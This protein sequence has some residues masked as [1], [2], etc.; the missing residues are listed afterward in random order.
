MTRS[1]R[2]AHR[3][4]AI[5]SLATSLAA[6]VPALA[7]SPTVVA[8]PKTNITTDVTDIWWPD[9]EPGWGIQLIQNADIIFATMFVYG[10]DS[11]PLFFVA[12][13]QKVAGADTWTGDLYQS[14]GTFFADT[15]NPADRA[16]FLAGAM[17][18]TLTGIGSGTLSYN[19]G[20]TSVV[21]QIS[22]QALK[23]EDNSG[24]YRMTHTW[25]AAGAGCT[26]SD[27]YSPAAGPV[28]GDL[29]ISRV[30]ADTATVS[31]T[32]QLFP[33]DTCFMTATYT[34]VGRLG[35]Y[36]GALA[37]SP[38]GRTGT[39]ALYEIANRPKMLTGRYEMAWN[40]GCTRSGQF[41][42]IMA[43]P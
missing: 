39:L 33:V 1:L 3:A 24:D 19:V 26:S 41:T 32:W 36:S 31:L 16:E 23:L 27:L 15:W 28:N 9:S 18:F 4:A 14:S 38:S 22:R 5:A 10:P 11:E 7:Q 8:F 2:A 35:S 43:T 42:A 12:T 21:K 34:Q 20:P 17:T 30:N 6:G 13:L 29:A 37:C 25:S 40:G